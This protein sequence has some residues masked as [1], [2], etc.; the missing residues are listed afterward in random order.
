[1]RKKGGP[2]AWRNRSLPRDRKPF[3]EGLLKTCFGKQNPK[4][5][6]SPYLYGQKKA[7]ARRW[8][9]LQEGARPVYSGSANWGKTAPHY[10]WRWSTGSLA[11]LAATQARSHVCKRGRTD[12]QTRASRSLYRPGGPYGFINAIRSGP[13][14]PA[15]TSVEA[16]GELS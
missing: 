6:Q 4:R 14:I 16:A 1:M 7:P 15:L 10:P 9:G 8:S 13:H 5:R 2:G 11:M 3:P 12:R